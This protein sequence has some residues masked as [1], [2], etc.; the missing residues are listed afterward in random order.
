MSESKF[1][2]DL[3]QERVFVDQRWLDRA[4][5]TELLTQRLASMD[6]NVA[7]LSAAMEQLDLALKQAETFD[8]RLP[9]EVAA[10][11]KDIA[12]RQGMPVG[13]VIREAVVSYLVGAALSK[14][15]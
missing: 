2:I 13:S 9:P 12:A 5:V 15:A 4:G 11:L 10:Q 1:D 8:V 7:Q 3:E 14:L 6:Y